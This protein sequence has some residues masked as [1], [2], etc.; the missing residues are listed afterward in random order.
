MNTT[1]LALRFAA[2]ITAISSL[3]ISCDDDISEVGS[4]ALIGSELEILEESN[5][6]I[7][8]NQ[9]NI[10]QPE[11]NNL[12]YYLIGDNV[13]EHGFGNTKYSILSQI[14]SASVLVQDSFIETPDVDEQDV[15]GNNIILTRRDIHYEL[16]EVE[17]V[18][19]FLYSLEDDE[20]V[21]DDESSTQQYKID[22]KIIGESINFDV[23]E[24]TYI[25]QAQDLNNP[26][27]AIQKYY[28]D[29]SD[30]VNQ[31]GDE[32][33]KNN[34]ITNYTLNLSS[35][36]KSFTVNLFDEDDEE[37]SPEGIS[38]Q[39]E[40][41]RIPLTN[42]SFK[43]RILQLITSNEDKNNDGSND[44]D[45]SLVNEPNFTSEV[46]KGIYIETTDENGIAEVL[47]LSQSF[48][49]SGIQLKFTETTIFNNLNE[50][51]DEDPTTNVSD[52]TEPAT[53]EEVITTLQFSSNPINILEKTSVSTALPDTSNNEDIILQSGLG[54]IGTINL[55]SEE[56]LTEWRDNNILLNDAILEFTV[57]TNSPFFTSEDDLPDT[58]FITQL[59]NGNTITDYTS[60]FVS[61]NEDNESLTQGHLISIRDESEEIIKNEEGNIIYKINITQ[62]LA[63][64][65]RQ[66]STVDTEDDQNITLALSVNDDL[67]L[68]NT[69]SLFT[70]NTSTDQAINQGTLLSFKTVPLHGSGA[71]EENI[72]RLTIKYTPTK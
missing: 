12:A 40:A 21:L 37:L 60:N 52:D 34:L 64:I 6:T 16:N 66:D 19:P 57:N 35:I 5:F 27:Q 72:P 1:F 55:F 39:F 70:S 13:N 68:I 51:D 58:I 4:S 23:Y 41:I 50:D 22:S 48:V 49:N 2:V 32:F 17:L 67:S 7:T 44:I 14:N 15:D 20:N 8:S 36:E 38:A 59:E 53:T 10:E 46:F 31:F 26:N 43:D 63:N 30:G 29:G 71:A 18:L 24:S 11:S 42:T 56:Q 3:F 54:R 62:H 45:L 65:L 69:S 61:T 28:A 25:L 33:I 9:I 47:D